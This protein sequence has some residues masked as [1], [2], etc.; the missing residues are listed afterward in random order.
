MN[1]DLAEN[2]NA[3]LR[4][5]QLEFIDMYRV[6]HGFKTRSD[7]LQYLV[8]KDIQ[9]EKFDFFVEMLSMLI[10]PMMGFFFFMILVVLTA[11][12]LFFLFMSVFGIFAVALCFIYYRKHRIRKE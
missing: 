10:L 9:Y 1:R 11:G 3:S 12:V 6:K 7:Y 5:S 8:D 4:H 2:A